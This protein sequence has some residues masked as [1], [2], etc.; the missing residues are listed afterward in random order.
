MQ[1]DAVVGS[2]FGRPINSRPA[3]ATL[4]PGRPFG[5]IGTFPPRPVIGSAQPI[6]Q[7]PSNGFD[8]ITRPDWNRP[9]NRPSNSWP[10][11]QKVPNLRS[12][13]TRILSNQHKYIKPE[14]MANDSPIALVLHCC[15]HRRRVPERLYEDTSTF[16]QF[17]HW[18]HLFNRSLNLYRFIN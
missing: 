7:E 8:P 14:Q 16:Q 1:N 4:A 3:A 2:L 18:H 11:R 6:P 12:N 5:G 13:M 10:N 17:L 9:G 15:R